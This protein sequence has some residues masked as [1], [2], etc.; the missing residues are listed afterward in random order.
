MAETWLRAAA[1]K[2]K[3]FIKETLEEFSRMGEFVRIYPARGTD[4]FD[5]YFSS[6]R[7]FNKLVY[8]AI[9]TNDVLKYATSSPSKQLKFRQEEEEQEVPDEPRDSEKPSMHEST[10]G[11]ST[12]LKMQN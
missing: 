4:N 8:K 11:S 12:S 10:K 7:F 2:H 1:I 6:N 5:R 3:L 9:Y